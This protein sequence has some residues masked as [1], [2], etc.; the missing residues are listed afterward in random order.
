[1]NFL[2]VFYFKSKT[3]DDLINC[4][5]AAKPTIKVS[6][7]HLIKSYA[8]NSVI[9]IVFIQSRILNNRKKN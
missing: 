1:M 9:F 8:A 6:F 4:K 3:Y 7:P 5:P 2:L